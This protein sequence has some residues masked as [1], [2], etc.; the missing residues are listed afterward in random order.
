MALH[1]R[2]LA[3]LPR[4]GHHGNPPGGD[5]VLIAARD[6]PLQYRWHGGY[7]TERRIRIIQNA[8]PGPCRTPVA[9][10]FQPALRGTSP[11][12]RHPVAASGPGHSNISAANEILGANSGIESAHSYTSSHVSVG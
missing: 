11:G 10:H 8:A 3:C 12:T 4:A 9:S 6:S 5:R 7:H 2:R 1:Q